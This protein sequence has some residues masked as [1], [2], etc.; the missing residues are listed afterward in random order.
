M[1]YYLGI[2]VSKGYADFVMINQHK[3][4]TEPGF[5]LD[6]TFDGHQRLYQYLSDFF[7]KHQNATL[8]AAVEST[9]GYENNW[10]HSLHKFQEF[11]NIQVARLNPKGVNHLAKAGLNR[12]ITDNLAAKNIAEYLLTHPEKV[13]YQT[14]DYYYPIRQKWNFIHSLTKEKTKH[15]NQLNSLLYKANPDILCYC[16][17]NVSQWVLKLLCKFPTAKRL[18]HA[19]VD[20]LTKIPYLTKNRALEI[21]QRSRNSVASANDPLTQDTIKTLAGEILRLESLIDR[22]N[23]LI[24]K[25]CPFPEIDLLKSFKSISDFSAIGLLVQIGS[26]KRF[27]TVKKLSSFFGMHPV[28]K[29]SGDGTSGMRMSKQGR[30]QPRAILFMVA[31]NAISQNPVIKKTYARNLAKGKCR[32]DAIGVCMHKILRIVYGMLKHNRPFDPEID[33]LNQKRNKQSK[34]KENQIKNLRRYHDLDDHAP[35]SKR[36]KIKRKELKSSQNGS[37]VMHE[38]ISETLSQN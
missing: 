37:T 8:F 38:I 7:K 4:I 17:D 20:Q 32:M 16:K 10:F 30:K 36:Q 34:P 21:I 24:A 2:D 14:Q 1:N 35:I 5:Q 11:F 29:T 13:D 18:A 27:P 22:Q 33:K 15:L 25:H 3:K 12:I 31:L 9:G 23:K 6:D 19:S 28:F 26:V